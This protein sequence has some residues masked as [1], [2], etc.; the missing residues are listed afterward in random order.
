MY[1]NVYELL[2]S[3]CNY[4]SYMLILKYNMGKNNL[5][6]NRKMPETFIGVLL[7]TLFTSRLLS[8]TDDKKFLK[9]KRQ[10]PFFSEETILILNK[11]HS[12]NVI[13]KS[14][15]EINPFLFLGLL[16]T[17]QG[18]RKLYQAFWK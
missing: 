12:G 2:K 4:L 11:G 8:K 10:F 16:F 6:T 3:L 7:R 13:F 5:N 17:K 18:W 14:Q 9:L 1:Y 15:K